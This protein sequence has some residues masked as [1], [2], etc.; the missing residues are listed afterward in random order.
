M[1]ISFVNNFN[2]RITIEM[3]KVSKPNTRFHL[4]P[5]TTRVVS[6]RVSPET[7]KALRILAA[8]EDMTVCAM[9]KT[10]AEKLVAAR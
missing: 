7:L 5:E 1:C 4:D 8:E 10:Q 6:L 9:L 2:V 3:T